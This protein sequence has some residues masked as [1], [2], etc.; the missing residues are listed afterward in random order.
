MSLVA[1][2]D[3][4]DTDFT[5]ILSNVF[6]DG[7]AVQLGASGGM[8]R[9]RYRNGYARQELLTPGKPEVYRIELYDIAHRFQ[10][11][12]RIRLNVSSS[13]VPLYNPNQ[14]TGL[15]IATDTTWRRAKRTISTIRRGHRSSRSG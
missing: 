15:P 3:G 10:P 12:H 1:A 13:A 7:R 11:G 9:G 5:A 8:R 2:G 4:F 6:P 14:N